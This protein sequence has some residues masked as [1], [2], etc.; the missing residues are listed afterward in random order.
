VTLDTFWNH[1]L[2]SIGDSQITIGSILTALFLLIVG[3]FVSRW[4]SRFGARLLRK[5]VGLDVGAESAIE[6]LG[7]YLL[8]VAFTFTSLNLVRFPLTIFTI[9]GGAVA[10]GA[11][12]GSQNLMNNFI[13]GLIIHLERPIR[14]GDLI[15]LEGTY[16][17]V[18]KIGARSTRIRAADNTQ[19][20]VPNS[21][22]LQ[23]N[24][25]NFTLS[26]DIVR[27][28]IAVGV[29]YGSPAREVERRIRQ[30]LDEHPGVLK[31]REPR[32][33]FSDFGDNALIFQALFWLRAKT[34]LERRQ[35]ESDLRF[36]ID[37]LFREAG[38]TIAFP[39]RDVHLDAARPVPVRLV[40][41]PAESE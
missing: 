23:N 16:G 2:V 1:V 19:I 5:R 25:V 29:A 32:I 27:T 38:I 24:L 10:I 12:F 39:Q 22:F 8:F 4:I 21:F 31:D 6:T 14:A 33:L 18:E 41:G 26:D 30:A 7:F 15:A 37:D 36:R 3:F 34:M 35:L 20:V 11:G 40:P 9:A 28:Q 13:S 17:T